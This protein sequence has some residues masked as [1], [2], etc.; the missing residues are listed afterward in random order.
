MLQ[1]CKAWRRGACALQQPRLRLASAPMAAYRPRPVWF[2]ISRWATCRLMQ[3][4]KRRIAQSCAD[5]KSGNAAI[6]VTDSAAL[7]APRIV[8]AMDVIASSGQMSIFSAISISSSSSVPRFRT[9]LAIWHVR[10]K[11]GLL[12]SVWVADKGVSLSS[13]AA[14]ACQTAQ[15]LARC[16]R[17]LIVRAGCTLPP[18][19]RSCRHDRRTEL[20]PGFVELV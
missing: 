4:N 2:S 13:V 12:K 9:V 6:L 15:G 10:A 5:P 14:S 1:Y 17:H 19:N 8:S 16:F 20:V 3:R 7:H 11:A 18:S